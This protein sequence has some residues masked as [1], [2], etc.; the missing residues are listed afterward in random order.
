MNIHEIR[1]ALRTS[2]RVYGS[3][4]SAPATLWVGMARGTDLDFVFIDTEHIPND[5]QHLS[6][7]CRTYQATGLPPIVR[8]PKPDPF[9]ACPVKFS[10]AAPTASSFHTSNQSPRS[11][12]LSAPVAIARL[13][14]TAYSRPS[15][16]PRALSLN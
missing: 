14:A 16:T 13:R 9:E 1:Q 5:C 11:A 7:M 10:T 15:T 3:L 12:T 2:D 8:V 6:W 4:V